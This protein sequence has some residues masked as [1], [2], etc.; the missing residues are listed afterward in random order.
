MLR[1]PAELLV[2]SCWI[3]GEIQNIASSPLDDL[4]WQVSTNG[5]TESFD[6]IVHGTSFTGSEIPCPYTGVVLAEVIEGDQ[7]A[8]CEVDD[9]DVVADCCAVLPR[10]VCP[11]SVYKNAIRRHLL[12]SLP[13]RP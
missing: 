11:S 8:F 10:V 7:V 5:F 12:S 13:T 2:R 1:L 6:H 9:M 3:S 4:I